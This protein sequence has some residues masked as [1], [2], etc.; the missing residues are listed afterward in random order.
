MGIGN[1]NRPQSANLKKKHGKSAE[2]MKKK[3]LTRQRIQESQGPFNN[4]VNNKL[5]NYSKEG[6]I[7]KSL[8]ESRIL[9]EGTSFDREEVLR[10]KVFKKNLGMAKKGEVKLQMAPQNKSIINKKSGS[11]FVMYKRPENNQ[12]SKNLPYDQIG[13]IDHNYKYNNISMDRGNFRKGSYQIDK[14]RQ[15]K[16]ITTQ[17]KK[18]KHKRSATPS[19]SVPQHILSQKLR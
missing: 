18:G 12:L 1:K 7:S 14:K 4:Y 10:H 5:F 16:V 2:R 8:A 11:K 3:A 17:S 15:A 6:A 19:L 13:Y 9:T